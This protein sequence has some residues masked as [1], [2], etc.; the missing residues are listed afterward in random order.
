MWKLAIEDDQGNRTVVALVRDE[1]SL[2]RAEANTVRLTERNVSRLHAR[3]GRNGEGWHVEDLSSYN[4]IYVNGLRVHQEQPLLA[5]DLLQL[6]DYR[7]S[8]VNEA[9]ESGVSMGVPGEGLTGGHGRPDAMID[10]DRLV[11][12]VGPEP[13]AE[14]PLGSDL[15]VVGRGDECD[16]IVN[17]A[18]V[19]RVHS[20][21]QALG[22][23]R[24]EILDK[25][26]ANGVRVN[27]VE[28]QRS[29][30][31]ARDSIELGDVVLKFIPAGQLYRP[32]QQERQELAALEAPTRSSEIG[33]VDASAL[34]KRPMPLT[35]KL[36]AGAAGLGVILLVAVLAVRGSGVGDDSP[37]HA[38]AGTADTASRI[39]TEAR[40][41]LDKG[42]IEGAHQKVTRELA[43]NS[44]AR[45][46]PEFR[47][48]E[49]HWADA[50]FQQAHDESD[51]QVKRALLDQIARSTSV[52]SARRKRAQNE[53]A[54]LDSGGV[55][56]KD[57]PRAGVAPS[58]PLEA[59]ATPKPLRPA[60]TGG[61]GPAP[62]PAPATTS[63]QGIIR[64]N[65]FDST[66]GE[67]KKS[68]Q[69]MAT[70]GDREQLLRAK[71]GLAAKV[72]AGTATDHDRKML[73]AICRQLGDP[74]CSN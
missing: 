58:L 27:G 66:S 49:A 73:R 10:Q 69:D 30:L 41:M 3:L 46:S 8:V 34:G 22:D 42:D 57:L 2:G 48:I 7:L 5:G 70:S 29:L 50:L 9:A 51:Q 62:R 24:Y 40:E 1:Y 68:L 13:G 23:G 35:A 32:T 12:V 4:G 11:M 63:T 20:E 38:A 67:P 74:T 54:A 18:S 53:I 71:A 52:D 55:D 61:D 72:R 64:S 19:S 21:I 33:A 25:G 36:A 65:P 56:V 39:L 43:E 6:G 15:I 31:D 37:E 28:L 17:H 26:S 47:N 45:Q 14:F 44:N 59:G 60:L 16:V